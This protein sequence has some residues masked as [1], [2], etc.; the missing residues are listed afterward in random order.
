MIRKKPGD[1]LGRLTIVKDT[2]KRTK[3]GHKIWLMKCECGKTK[4][5][6]NDSKA[7]SC[8]CYKIEIQKK[9]A[10]KRATK[11]GLTYKNPR[12]YSIWESLKRR[13]NNKNFK[14][15]HRYG[16]RGIS[17]C[18]EWENYG[19][20]YNWAVNNGYSAILTLDRI[21]NDGN[22]EPNNCKWSTRKEQAN[23]RKQRTKGDKR[24]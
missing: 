5:I 14:H 21:N 15:Y 7:I 17:Y 24:A 6:R 8:G 18:K 11:H 19:I 1:I 3:N 22:Y 16:G 13:C 4:E 23:N 10:K 9:I 20:F 2:G 12:L